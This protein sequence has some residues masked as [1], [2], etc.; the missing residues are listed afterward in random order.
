MFYK[1][2]FNTLGLKQSILLEKRF[3]LAV[4]SE[5]KQYVIIARINFSQKKNQAI[6]NHWLRRKKA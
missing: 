1:R 3:I 6:Q 2:F 4:Q 5:R